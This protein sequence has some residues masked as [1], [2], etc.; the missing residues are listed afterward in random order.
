MASP[1]HGWHIWYDDDDLDLLFWQRTPAGHVAGLEVDRARLLADVIARLPESAG[2]ERSFALL[3]ARGEVLHQ[4]GGY[5]PPK[6]EAPLATVALY[7][8]LASWRLV[9]HA[10]A[11]ALGRLSLGL[12]SGLGMGLAALGLA[13]SG[14]ALFLFREHTRGLRLAEQRVSF[15]NRVSHELKTPLTNI[16]L[17]AELLQERIDEED[18]DATRQIDVVVAE[19]SGSG[20]SSTTS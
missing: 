19:G 2:T 9:V 5:V 14:L 13:L 17:Y 18:E 1:A 20:A 6:D 8:P 7:P 16:R 11:Q 15:V 12:W 10:P 3:D 4:W